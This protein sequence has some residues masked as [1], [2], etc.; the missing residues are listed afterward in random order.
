M[1]DSP[2]A[3]PPV[4]RHPRVLHVLRAVDGRPHRRQHRTMGARRL[5]EL[6]LQ[7]SRVEH[8]ALG[9]QSR[10]ASLAGAKIYM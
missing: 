2:T 7:P 9:E 10:D 1:A 5:G 8:V 6:Q 3:P 4:H